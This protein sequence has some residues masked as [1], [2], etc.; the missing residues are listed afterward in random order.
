MDKCDRTSVGAIA[1]DDQG[2]ILMIE[3]KKFPFGFAPPAGH[4]D[5][6]QYPLACC[7]EFR[8]ETGLEIIGAPKPLILIQNARTNNRCRRGGFCHFWQVFEVGWKGELQP[9]R[10]ETKWVGWI[11]V[12]EIRILAAQTQEYMQRLKLA[13]K[14]EEKSWAVSIKESIE[15]QW[16][17][18][19]GLEVV[20]F[21]IFR[22][23]GII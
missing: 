13:E 10:D 2:K 19:P 4:C 3:R 11:S 12:E 22:E 17:E 1:R 18:S 23:L 8:Q 16:Q 7:K 15:K 20:W 14:A 6:D 5:G 21:D 9:S